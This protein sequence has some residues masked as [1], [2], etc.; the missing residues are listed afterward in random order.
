MAETAY[1]DVDGH[2]C[3]KEEM[4]LSGLKKKL[5]SALNG[6]SGSWSVY[7]KDL[8]TNDVLSINEVSMYPASVIKL[9]V[10]EAVYASVS[11]KRISM[12]SNVKSLLNS[13]ITV[14]DNESYNALVRIVGNG[15]FAAGC[16]Y[17]NQYIKKMGGTG[18]GVHHT[19]HPAY[20]S[21][22]SDGWGSNRS[23]A[24]DIGL[25][26]ERIYRGKAV[27]RTYSAQMRDLLL[28]QERRWKIPAGLPYGVKCANKTGETDSYQH[29]AAIVYGKK[30]DYVIV[31][32]SASSEYY[33]TNG[34]K[35]IS[36]MV[37]DYL[38]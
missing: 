34:I 3:E 35:K 25:L 11:Q 4:R 23:S 29:D 15:S 27:S 7:V 26:M 24:R 22:Q 1:V 14:S 31:I 16:N 32:F 18:S 28:Q 36:S 30:T 10:M 12:T 20:S 9:W 37:Y 5:Q 8:K 19:L 38:N 2:K 17:I 21:Y 33:G 13:M 6:Y